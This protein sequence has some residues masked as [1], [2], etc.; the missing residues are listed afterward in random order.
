MYGKY[1]FEKPDVTVNGVL[2]TELDYY[3]VIDSVDTEMPYDRK[4]VVK[5]NTIIGVTVTKTIMAYSHPDHDDYFIVEYIL[6]N[7]GI[8]D[9]AGTVHQQT[10]EDV[11]MLNYYRYAFAGEACS[12]YDQGWSAWGATWGVNTLNHVVQAGDGNALGEDLGARRAFYS[13]YMPHSERGEWDIGCPNDEAD[14]DDEIVDEHMSAAKYAGVVT[15]HADVSATDDSDDPQQPSSTYFVDSDAPETQGVSAYAEVG[16]NQRYDLMTAGHPAST[17]WEDFQNQGLVFGDMYGGSGGG[18][19]SQTF[20]YGPY[21]LEPDQSVRIVI[22]EGVKGLNRAKN[23]ELTENWLRKRDGEAPTM[24][25]PNGG[26]TGDESEYLQAWVETCRDS[27]IKTLR[28]AKDAFDNEY[29]VSQNPDPPSSFYVA[30]G[31][32]RIQLDWA[33]NAESHPNFTGYEVWRSTGSIYATT[34]VYEKIWECDAN[35]SQTS[36][37]DT[38][39]VRGFSY[40]YYVLSKANVDG[41]ILRSSK[42]YTMTSEPASLLRVAGKSLEAIRVVPNPY[43]ISKRGLQFQRGELDWDKIMFYDVPAFCKIKIFTERGDLVWETEHTNTSGD[44]PWWSLT[45]S[46]QVVASGVYIAY[47][48][49]TQDYIHPETGE[50]AY[51]K[52]ENTYRKFMIIR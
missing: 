31:G 14:P 16:M 27:I 1:D 48:E 5:F 50:T 35:D 49:V 25:L 36:F 40:F 38:S 37:G 7:T 30:G 42:F 18:G 15:L 19:R 29:I 22:A 32:D 20:S 46:G 28:A 21:T 47:F 39:A 51:R 44:E 17:H 3:D 52:G 2:A 11:Y 43:V 33:D 23:R 13:W 4:I 9:A 6:T 8:Q 45:S 12:G 41:R 26:T 10:L 34:A 24:S